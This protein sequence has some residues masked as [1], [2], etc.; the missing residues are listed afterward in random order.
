MGIKSYVVT[1]TI[2]YGPAEYLEWCDEE[3]IEPTQEGFKEFILS[4]V[5]DD[6]TSIAELAYLDFKEV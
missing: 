5:Y 6:F 3:G 1:R 2:G 4:W